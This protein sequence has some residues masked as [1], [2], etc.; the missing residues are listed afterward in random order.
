MDKGSGL[1]HE[2][3]MVV[4]PRG[5]RPHE[6]LRNRIAWLVTL[7][8]VVDLG[9]TTG[10]WLLERGDPHTGFTTWAGA[11]FWTTAQLT[12]VSSQLPNP[13]TP[14]GKALDIVLELWSVSVV[15]TLAAS[16]ASFFTHRH[17]AEMKK[18]EH[19]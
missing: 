2:M 19:E 9:G 10:A 15:A 5:S 8:F 17:I 16:L 18:K 12:T 13:V 14:G 4:N 3:G 1:T 11:L 6:L 7:T